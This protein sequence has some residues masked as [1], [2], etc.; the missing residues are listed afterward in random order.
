MKNGREPPLGVPPTGRPLDQSASRRADPRRWRCR[1]NRLAAVWC[2]SGV[3]HHL[4]EARERTPGAIGLLRTGCRRRGT[5]EGAIVDGVDT[6]PVNE[7]GTGGSGCRVPGGRL[8]H[9]DLTL[10]PPL[11]LSVVLASG[12]ARHWQSRLLA[13]IICF[14]SRPE[15]SA[16]IWASRR[17]SS[18]A[19]RS[20]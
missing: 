20:R 5:E 1:S 12:S 10:S 11:G 14:G 6:R 4:R 15:R 16:S 19:S 18:R 17:T 9:L 3:R 7:L 13:S 8:L 2:W